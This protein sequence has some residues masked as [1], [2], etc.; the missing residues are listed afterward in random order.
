[1]GSKYLEMF[2]LCI[3]DRNSV[4]V[5]MAYTLQSVMIRMFWLS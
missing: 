4:L 2:L 1:M 5:F 3:G